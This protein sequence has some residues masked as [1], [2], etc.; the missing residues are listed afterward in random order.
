MR[1]DS[2][3]LTY[4]PQDGTGNNQR[5]LWHVSCHNSNEVPT[6]TFT[7]LDTENG[8]DFVNIKDGPAPCDDCDNLAHVSGGMAALKK[9][10]SSEG[11]FGED[12]SITLCT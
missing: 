4:Q 12:S 10:A 2:G 1:G 3:T 6:F 11:L 8:W 5:C 9:R 7:A